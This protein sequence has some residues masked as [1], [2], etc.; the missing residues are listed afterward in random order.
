[1]E[2]DRCAPSRATRP[3]AFV[4]LH[5]GGPLGPN[6]NRSNEVRH[7]SAADQGLQIALIVLI[8]LFILSA[9]AAYLG[10]KSYSDSEQRGAELQSQLNDQRTQV[11]NLQTENEDLRFWMGFGRNDNITDVKTAYEA[12]MKRFGA[13]IADETRRF[14]RTV[15]ESVFNE[16]AV[17]AGRLAEATSQRKD[18]MASYESLEAQTNKQITQ[19]KDA[20]KKLEEDAAGER[21]K[22]NQK[23]LELEN[24]E[25]ELLANLDKQRTQLEGQIAD[26]DAQIKAFVAQVAELRRAVVNWR[27][28]VPSDVESFEVADGRISWVNQNGTVWINVGEADSLR[29]Q[30][31]FNVYDA[32]EHDADRAT[33]KGSIEVTKL[34]GDHLA[35]ASV[36]QDDP[37]NP[38]LTGD[39]IYSPVWHRGKKLRFALTGIIDVDNDGVSDLQLVRDLIELNG[40]AADAYLGDDGKVVGEI[41]AH[42][43]YLVLGEFPE[44]AVRANMQEGWQAMNQKA[45]ELG[46]ETITLEQ[47]LSR[48]GYTTLD[49]T[50]PLGKGATA[51]DFPARDD[52]GNRLPD[53]ETEDESPQFRPRT[54]Y[55]TPVK[56]PF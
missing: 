48:M 12:D 39:N 5:H 29:R 9:V 17:T 21:N 14:Y 35:E 34:L 54:P 44:S 3:D 56:T 13:A 27:E 49:R 19:Y 18:L 24:T 36:T 30:V 37:T 41:T 1:L 28:Q 23:R 33:K 10:L 42:T 6:G 32:D 22:F 52:T 47:F 53:V 43:R 7:G 46:V 50:V 40:G 8:F 16:S 15:L 55:H 51:R 45:T 20:N 11:N 38:I 25:K 2:R 26:R 31:T 4:K